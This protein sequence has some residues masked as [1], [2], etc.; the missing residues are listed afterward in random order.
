MLYYITFYY[1]FSAIVIVCHLKVPSLQILHTEHYRVSLCLSKTISFLVITFLALEKNA[2]LQQT[3]LVLPAAVWR[4]LLLTDTFGSSSPTRTVDFACAEVSARRGKLSAVYAW[5]W[6]VATLRREW[7]TTTIQHCWTKQH[8]VCPTGSTPGVG[9][10]AD[11]ADDSCE[12]PVLTA[13][14][15]Q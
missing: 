13:A 4:L 6:S 7:Q 8:S 5:A 3:W 12:A 15:R 2:C 1:T 14:S 10:P 9:S 11:A